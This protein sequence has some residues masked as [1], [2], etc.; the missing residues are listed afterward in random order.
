VCVHCVSVCRR[1]FLV[2]VG[3]PSNMPQCQPVI[4]KLVMEAS[5][6]NRIYVASIQPDL[7]EQDVRTLV[8]N[9]NL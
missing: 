4:E 1:L 7:T 8:L 6:Y 3:R 9:I 2:Q 5:K